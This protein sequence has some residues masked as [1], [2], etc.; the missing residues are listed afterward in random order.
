MMST[1]TTKREL[2]AAE[3]AGWLELNDLIESLSPAQM[4]EPGYFPEGWSV[5]DL[6]AH[7]GLQT[8]HGQDDPTLLLKNG[9]QALLLMQ[10]HRD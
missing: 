6:M 1:M 10:M 8:I 7:I 5:K 2:Q 9:V 3:D 4:E